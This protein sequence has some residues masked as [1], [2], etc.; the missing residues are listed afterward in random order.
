MVISGQTYTCPAAGGQLSV[1][2]FN[3]YINCPAAT[4]VCGTIGSP[5]FQQIIPNTGTDR[6][7]TPVTVF[8][9]LKRLVSDDL[10]INVLC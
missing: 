3:G 1:T 4:A 5:T 6:G 9:T 8:G 10:S 2:G 7:G